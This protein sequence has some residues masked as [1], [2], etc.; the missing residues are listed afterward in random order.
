M[1]KNIIDGLR[2]GEWFGI[3]FNNKVAILFAICGICL[4]LG[5]YIIKKLDKKKILEAIERSFAY[6]FV[7]ITLGMILQFSGV[8]ISF[9][10]SYMPMFIFSLAIIITIFSYG[11]E[12]T[13]YKFNRR[14][15]LVKA[16]E[17]LRYIIF[18]EVLLLMVM[19]R[20]DIIETVTAL[21]SICFLA[22]AEIY[23]MENNDRGSIE[24]EN[25]EILSDKPISK[26]DDLFFRRNIQLNNFKQVLCRISDEP[27]AVMVSGEWGSGKTSFINVFCETMENAEFVRVEGGVKSQTRE[28][29]N[30]IAVQI[31]KI[32][33]AN[34]IASGGNKYISSYFGKAAD[35]IEGT[36][37]EFVA[38]ILHDVFK[39]KELDYN[40]TKESINN[41][42]IEFH[43]ITHKKIFIIVDN[44][45]R[46]TPKE[47][48]KHFEVIRESVLL[49][50]C[51][52]IFLVDYKAFKT[53]FLNDKFLEK[54]VN[55]HVSL[56][57]MTYDELLKEYCAKIFSE[58]FWLDKSKDIRDK[59]SNL[60]EY[61]INGPFEIIEKLKK[62]IE[63][64]NSKLSDGELTNDLAV[65]YRE[66]VDIYTQTVLKLQSRMSNP[67]KLIRFLQDIENMVLIIDNNWF[68][69]TDFHNNEYSSCD[70]FRDIFEISFLKCYLTEEYDTLLAE[71]NLWSYKKANKYNQVSIVLT[72][73]DS[74]VGTTKNE[75]LL[76]LLIYRVY[77]L[78]LESDKSR[79]QKLLDDIKGKNL[80]EFR[81]MEYINEGLGLYSDIEYFKNVLD[82]IKKNNFI[83]K[84]IKVDSVIKIIEILFVEPILRKPMFKEIF[85]MLRQIVDE[86]NQA[87]E[88]SESNNRVIKRYISNLETQ[89]IFG[90]NSN[91]ANVLKV[92]FQSNG[93]AFPDN[94]DNLDSLYTCIAKIIKENAIEEIDISDQKIML[95]KQFIAYVKKKFM[96]DKYVIMREAAYEVLE[97]VECGLDMLQCWNITTTT[98]TEEIYIDYEGGRIV[99]KCWDS[100]DTWLNS[101]Q[102]LFSLLDGDVKESCI[103]GVICNFMM[104]TEKRVMGNDSVFKGKEMVVYEQLEQLYS[105]VNKRIPQA[106]EK[107]GL[108]WTWSTIRMY[109]IKEHAE[110]NS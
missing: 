91:F 1:E 47:R 102:K 79:H 20:L 96:D 12:I 80:S 44:L 76:Q 6:L 32:F 86:M 13:T 18:L 84:K 97:S 15:Q 101:I 71:G 2:L 82:F 85:I 78:D 94:C 21:I 5:V 59:K 64:N 16:T 66:R 10:I 58:K 60:E 35:M 90:I 29:L 19:N 109:R 4:A 99:G 33:K 92:L 46:L 14:D 87:R 17:T 100:M 26:K 23:I 45:D 43:N 104:E 69:K 81:L 39:D 22:I 65:M 42:L 88:L 36:G 3:Y 67:R 95:I 56:T 7:I 53:E 89:A 83:D 72:D 77:A 51:V 31:N 74:S 70:W 34:G 11:I 50:N 61:V 41:K 63:L 52:T 93:T 48:E 108:P 54:Y 55:Y 68:S 57:P 28:M 37:N 73:L 27:F 24:G 106:K 103:N 98:L 110:N 105:E 75:E 38:K 9:T 30:D 8:N 40:E 107:W 49:K 62:N 25:I